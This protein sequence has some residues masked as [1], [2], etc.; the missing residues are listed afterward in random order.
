MSMGKHILKAVTKPK[1][2]NAKIRVGML[3]VV[4]D[5]LLYPFCVTN[6]AVWNERADPP[7]F[8][9]SDPNVVSRIFGKRYCSFVWKEGNVTFGGELHVTPHY[10]FDFARTKGD[11]IFCD[12]YVQK[13]HRR[14]G[15]DR[16]TPSFLD[17]R[18][19][20]ADV[21]SAIQFIEHEVQ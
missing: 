15:E 4:W 21:Q 16:W 14:K 7:C 20:D 2:F 11:S 3:K 6:G 9:V 19:D 12:F 17:F 5:D 13:F 1:T 18:E 10:P 8:R